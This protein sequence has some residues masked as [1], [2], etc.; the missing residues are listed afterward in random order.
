[1]VRLGFRASPHSHGQYVTDLTW[2][3]EN[4]EFDED[5]QTAVPRNMV[6][7]LMRHNAYKNYEFERREAIRDAFSQ[8]GKG[9][10]RVS[11]RFTTMKHSLYTRFD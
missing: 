10:K 8:I 4:Q 2:D 7:M 9:M 11:E 3:I 1:M 5:D 6:P